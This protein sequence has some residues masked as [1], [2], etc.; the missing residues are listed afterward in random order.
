[1]PKI[2]QGKNKGDGTGRQKIGNINTVSEVPEV[3][4]CFQI[5]VIR[6]DL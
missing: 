6:E 2:T 5:G 4:D 1:M 3:R